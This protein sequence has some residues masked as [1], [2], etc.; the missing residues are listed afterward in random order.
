[1]IRFD[2]RSANRNFVRQVLSACFLGLASLGGCSSGDRPDIDPAW[3]L[4]EHGNPD[5]KPMNFEDA[6][7]NSKSRYAELA[8]LPKPESTP[9]ARKFRQILRWLP[10]FAA[11]TPIKRAGWE[12]LKSRMIRMEAASREP[13]FFAQDRADA[14]DQ[15]MQSIAA[16]VPP[17]TLYRKLDSR[18]EAANSGESETHETN[19]GSNVAGFET[20]AP[21]SKGE[22]R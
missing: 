11:D 16:L 19:S 21:Q 6:L 18:D 1:M 12:E 2:F 20:S 14:F 7:A 3:I 4:D 8:K 17:D 5:F 13:G 15:E 10:D 9:E 22:Q